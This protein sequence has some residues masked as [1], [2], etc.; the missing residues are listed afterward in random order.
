MAVGLDEPVAVIGMS[1]RCAGGIDSPAALWDF[2]MTG[3]NAVGSI[4]DNRW[5]SYAERGW[6]FARAIRG[7][8]SQGSFLADVSGFDAEFFGMTA[9]EARLVDPQHRLAMELAWEALEHA[10]VPARSLAGT[11][12]G[13]WVGIGSEDYGRRLLEDLPTVEPW[14]GI[15]SSQCGAPNRVSYALDLRGPSVAVDTACSSSLVAVHQAV[16]ALRLGEV[17]LALAGGVMVMSAPGLS[18]VL[19]RAGATA[20]DGRSKPFDA[21]ADGYGRG[22]GGALLVLKRLSDARRDGDRV[23][24][25]LRG[26]AVRQDGRT[27]GIMAPSGPAQEHLLRAAYAA[28]G[29]DPASVGYVEA[30]GTG[31]RAG[32]PVEAGALAAVLGAGRQAEQPC[33]IGSVKG[34][35]GHL[36]AGAG[37][38]GLVKAVLAVA[39]GTIPP[40]ASTAGP[41][42][43]IPWER[44][45]LRLVTEPTPF[46]G[47][48]RRAG[49]AGYGYGGTIAHLVV[50]QAPPTAPVP[51]PHSR[52]VLFPVSGDSPEALRDN[53]SRLADWLR[54]HPEADLAAVS[55]TLATR[56]SHLACRAVVVAEDRDDLVAGLGDLRGSTVT[57]TEVDPVFVFSG[58]GAQWAGM[59]R[60][61]LAEEPV[62]A[63]AIDELDPVYAA[64][65]G[66][67]ARDIITG[68]HPL[69]TDLV[70]AAIVAIQLALTD[71]WRDRGVRPAAVVGHS[72]GE[73][74]AAAAAGVL[75]RADAARLACRRAVL[76]RQVAGR[77][78]MV[79]VALPFAEVAA[80]LDGDPHVTAAIESSPGTTVV[81]GSPGAVE[82]VSARF[83]ALGAPVRRVDSDVA[84]HGPQ[85]RPLCAG[86]A[87]AAASLAAAQPAVPLYSTALP[88]PRDPADRDAGY[89]VANL[90]NPVRFAGAVTA[91]VA[92][93]HRVFLEVST[94]PVVAHSIGE[95]APEVAVAHT[96]RRHRPERR[97]LLENAAALHAAGGRVDWTALV[98]RAGLA[99]LPTTAWQRREHWAG[100]RPRPAG[101][102][103]HDPAEQ[104]L[105][106]ADAITVRGP[107]PV[108][109]WHTRLDHDSRPYPGDHPVAGSE[110]VPAAVLLNTFLRAAGTTALRDVRLRVPVATSPAREVQ[111][112]AQDGALRLSSRVDGDWLTHTTA[113]AGTA[114]PPARAAARL[115]GTRIP[116][117]SV[118]TRLARLGVLS[119]GLE[120]TVTELRRGHRL[121][122]ARV[123]VPGTWA[124][125]LDAVLSTA[126]VAFPGPARLRMPAAVDR[127]SLAQEAPTDAVFSVRVR[128]G[129]TVDVDIA[130]ASGVPAGMLRGL[131]FGTPDADGAS[132]AG[133]LHELTWQP[134][135]APEHEPGATAAVLGD[136]PDLV[137]ALGSRLVPADRAEVLV[138]APEQTGDDTAAA[139]SDLVWRLREVVLA[140]PGRRVV[141]VTRGVRTARAREGLAQTALW[142]M[143]RGLAAEY[144]EQWG[145]VLDLVADPTAE[146]LAAV[147]R[148]VG[149]GVDEDVVAV[150]GGRA[151][152]ARLRAAVPGRLDGGPR[153]RPDGTYLV[154][155]GSG[156]LGGRVA[157][158]LVERGARRLLLLSRSGRVGRGL[159]ADLEAAGATVRGLAADVADETATRA[160]LAEVG[161]PPVRGVVHAAGAV[162]SGAAAD[163]TRAELDAVL[164]PKVAGSLV[165]HRVF[166]PGTLD[167]LVLFSS[168]GQLLRLPGQAAYSAA[169]AFLDGLAR[170]RRSLGDRDAVA[171]AWT[172]WRG[173]GMAASAA[174]VDAELAARGTD[175]VSAEE[176]LRAWSRVDS[177]MA[178][179][180]AV[181]RVLPE[182]PG[183]PDP[184]DVPLLRG[185]VER[186]PARRAPVPWVSLTGQARV[187]FLVAEVRAAAAEVL[188][189]APDRVDPRRPL[190][191]LGL[192]S[193]LA[194]ALRRELGAR[195][196]V[197]VAA[198]LL[199]HHPTVTAIAHHLA[200]DASAPRP[201]PERKTA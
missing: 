47:E 50:E 75:S 177:G 190:P 139:V 92:D 53:G 6:E 65:L 133:L 186:G 178:G 135:T 200:R 59:G 129:D 191:E 97:T 105:L 157:R 185:L 4:P 195:L 189:A 98:P 158:W 5:K 112:S 104:S 127:L 134:V 151:T 7:R 35:V 170:H 76:L 107:V 180:L 81:S 198:T 169:N 182:D 201:E 144:P 1:C 69:G 88:D 23:L 117:T 184:L 196:G 41:H 71:V 52:P 28:S 188:G 13:V 109:V 86:L 181:L 138:F 95:T 155:G 101:G 163:L 43:G 110:I 77:G 57:R 149:S 73:I 100:E 10:G 89:W 123:E 66:L 174:A 143:A 8:V 119:M 29:V 122:S 118:V 30:H 64:E 172:S 22:E 131:R 70:Q 166:P 55:D 84:F 167:F 128:T 183:G 137:A 19:D 116:S 44:N 94:H 165:L 24:A 48:V 199:W 153:C 2:L 106:G 79:M 192:D 21:A 27:D 115:V 85:M 160:A 171:L 11:D 126:S 90:R 31:T 42:P 142:G 187:D 38:V 132:A 150:A 9:R 58:H 124:E 193:L 3:S 145:G 72:V 60:E 39:S 173:L 121:L 83:A 15:G 45:G 99:D 68:A 197:T 12:T 156:A 130:S 159:R 148:L 125:L 67:S 194:V 37:A 16:Q 17:P 176:A 20:P 62:F 108:T 146:D 63:R 120:W 54:S 113:T 179:N 40:T 175:A 114:G 61:L 74:A 93:G 25:V 34:N 18:V 162:L 26:G 78:A 33:L 136:A 140:H 168:A 87:E 102:R 96:L 49:V 103:G 56:R 164:A 147:A 111:V 91:A 154:T 82:R 14:T 152:A 51:R 141:C 36:E 46:P 80:R 32:D 161:F